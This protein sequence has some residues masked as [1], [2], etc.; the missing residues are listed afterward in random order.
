MRKPSLQP[1]LLSLEAN[2]VGSQDS[3]VDSRVPTAANEVDREREWVGLAGRAFGASGYTQKTAGAVLDVDKGT[4]SAQL[5]CAPN[6]HLSFRKMWKLGPEFWEAL[7]PLICEFHGI[8]IGQ[9]QR[10]LEDAAIGRCV[11]EAVLRVVGQ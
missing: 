3:R 4:L 6:R 9:T 7:I 5:A 1:P 2:R 10:D 11:R 8:T